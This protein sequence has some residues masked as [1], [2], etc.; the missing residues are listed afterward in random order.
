MGVGIL[1][2][3]FFSSFID[4]QAFFFFLISKGRLFFLLKL[5]GRFF[6][7]FFGKGCPILKPS[8]T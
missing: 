5:V 2:G 4:G 7:C 1:G 6:C 3:I 8:Q